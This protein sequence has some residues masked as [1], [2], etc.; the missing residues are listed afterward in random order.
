MLYVPAECNGIAQSGP[1]PPLLESHR[2]S[3]LLFLTSAPIASHVL[4][5]LLCGHAPEP[6]CVHP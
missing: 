5:G 6:A 2:C 4:R 3:P 1:A